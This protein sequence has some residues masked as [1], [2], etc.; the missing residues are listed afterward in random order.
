M[1]AQS[2]EEENTTGALSSESGLLQLCAE[3]RPFLEPHES[4]VVIQLC[5]FGLLFNF[6]AIS[7]TKSK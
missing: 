6:S 2:F 3:L 4:I 7:K 1:F 5:P